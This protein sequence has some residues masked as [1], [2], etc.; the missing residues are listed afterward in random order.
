MKK[1][2]CNEIDRTIVMEEN[3]IENDIVEEECIENEIGEE[4][5]EYSYI[6]EFDQLLDMALD[7]KKT[8][9]QT[10]R[11]E[12]NKRLPVSYTHL[13]LPTKA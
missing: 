5:G 10:Q 6:K 13:T 11:R 3:L 4:D 7:K 8:L 9:N 1:K 2:H 12:T